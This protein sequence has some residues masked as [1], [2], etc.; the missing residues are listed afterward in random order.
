MTPL[1]CGTEKIL[2]PRVT[3]ARVV[4]R[5]L[6]TLDRDTKTPAWE[7]ERIDGDA[8]FLRECLRAPLQESSHKLAGLI[9]LHRAS[10]QEYGAKEIIPIQRGRKQ[11]AG[12][13][14]RP[15]HDLRVGH[16][17]LGHKETLIGTKENPTEGG[18]TIGREE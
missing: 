7:F 10:F 9:T 13:V 6:S 16:N 14:S 17:S 15:G 1:E 8:R 4:R 18:R 11:V 2:H 3:N 5:G 12:G